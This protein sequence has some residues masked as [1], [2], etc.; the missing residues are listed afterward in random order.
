MA[1]G[2]LP[3]NCIRCKPDNF[4]LEVEEKYSCCACKKTIAKNHKY[5]DCSIC[6]SRIH[7]KCNKTD[8]LSYQKIKSDNSK[9]ICV[10]CKTD[11]IP[12]QSLSDLELLATCK[13]I[14]NNIETLEK[15]SCT[16]TSL[17]S[18]FQEINKT[19]PFENKPRD[20]DAEDD[21]ILI[22]CKYMDVC[23]FNLKTDPNKFSIFHT[24]IGSIEKHIEELRTTISSIPDFKFD[25][26]AITETKIK[27]N[28]KPKVS[29]QLQDYKCYHVDTESDKGGS[30]LYISNTINAKPRPDLEATLYK[31]GLLETTVLEITNPNSKNILITCIYRHPS[32]DLKEFNE[33]YLTPFKNIFL[34]VTLM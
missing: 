1:Q 19:N 13:G 28:I 16:S 9:I 12:F 7:I 21:T 22:D 25:I 5:L 32:M 31:T 10:N 18:F 8:P 33:D 15:V 2:A 29:I 30:L 23:S 20:R 3:Q 14:E 17:R 34:L 4:P 27:K 26:I 11:C 6:Y 24:N